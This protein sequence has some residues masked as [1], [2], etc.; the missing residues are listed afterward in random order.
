MV[1]LDAADGKVNYVVFAAKSGMFAV[2]AKI[3]IDGTGDSDLAAGQG[4][5]MKRRCRRKNDGRNLC[6]LWATLTGTGFE[7]G[8]RRIEDALKTRCSHTK[9][10][11]CPECGG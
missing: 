9:T 7:T 10:V 11:I 4:R 1:A 5:S 3:Y 8:H 6:S 2:K